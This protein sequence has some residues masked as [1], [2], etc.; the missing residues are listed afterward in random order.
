MSHIQAESIW[1]TYKFVKKKMDKG[2][3]RSIGSK[4]ATEVGSGEDQ[5]VERT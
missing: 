5:K 4:Q 3:T 2:R 1:I